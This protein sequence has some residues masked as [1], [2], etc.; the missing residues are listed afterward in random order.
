MAPTIRWL[1]EQKKTRDP[2]KTSLTVHT[3]RHHRNAWAAV[4]QQVDSGRPSSVEGERSDRGV[5]LTTDNVAWLE[6]GPIDGAAPR[7]LTIDDQAL[8][9]HDFST[10]H[11]FS[12]SV[13]GIGRPRKFRPGRNSTVCLA[14][15]AISSWRRW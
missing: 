2:D 15:L 11:R 8:G 6:V 4:E 13:A 5:V 10:K 14:P 1:L 12:S 3:L 9:T 7:E